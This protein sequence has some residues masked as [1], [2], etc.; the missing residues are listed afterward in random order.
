MSLRVT[1]SNTKRFFKRTMQSFKSY[2]PRGYQRLHKTPPCNPFSCT[3][4]RHRARPHMTHFNHIYRR[5]ENTLNHHTK[6]ATTIKETTKYL[7][8]KEPNMIMNTHYEV[9]SANSQGKKKMDDGKEEEESSSKCLVTRKL[10]ELKMMDRNNVDLVLDIE[11][12]LHYYSRL[13]SPVYREI[14][15][16]FFVEMYSGTFNFSGFDNS[17]SRK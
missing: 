12:V 13:T 1:Y 7:N 8:V 17:V 2:F 14:M 16:K 3:G 6:V 4:N 5:P 11:E 9:D 15:E 10:K